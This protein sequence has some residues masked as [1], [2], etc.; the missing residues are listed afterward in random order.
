MDPVH[1]DLVMASH[2]PVVTREVAVAAGLSPRA[3]DRLVRSGRWVAVRRGVYASADHVAATVHRSDRQRLYDDAACLR[4]SR[5]HVR[6]HASAAVVLGMQVLLPSDP[7]THVTRSDVR[8]SR[9]EHG[10]KHHLAPYRPEQVLTVDG[11]QVLDHAR[12][13]LDISR[14][15]GL[16]AGVVAVDSAMRAGVSPARLRTTLAAMPCWPGS[17]VMRSAIELGD[18]GADSL[19]ETLGRLLASQLGRG[20]PQTQFGLRADGRTAYVDLRV[21]RQLIEIDGL[22]KYLPGAARENPIDV[23]WDEKTRQDWLCGFKLGMSRLTWRDVWPL[24]QPQVLRRLEREIADTEQ[25]FGSDISDLDPYVVIRP[26]L[27]RQL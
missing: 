1:A 20:R 17:T 21:G 24:G 12:T 13:A 6:S 16:V 15:E 27:P 3:I 9:H 18:A 7:T 19:A 11:I 4:V 14:E 8:G 10:V 2:G 5:P 22:V 26:P 23:L 25:R